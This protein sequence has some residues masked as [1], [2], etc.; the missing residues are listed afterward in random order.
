MR[1]LLISLIA[2]VAAGIVGVA[3]QS[4]S[5]I[6]LDNESLNY[7]V[8]YKWGLINKLAGHATM[9]LV[10]DGENYRAS[11]VASNAS[12][13]N[14]IYFLRD[15]L[16]S[17]MTKDKL[18]PIDYIFIAHEN[19]KYRKETVKFSRTGDTFFGECFRTIRKKKDG[20][21][22]TTETSLE[23]KGMTVDML[24]T[25]FYLR[26]LDFASMK[27][28]DSDVINIFSAKKKEKLS[29]TYR[30]KAKVK[31]DGKEH[32]TY[33]LSFTFTR[34]GVESSAPI[35]GWISADRR[36]IP[37]KVEGS[38]PVGKVRAIFSGETPVK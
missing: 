2:A 17:T 30:G 15:T 23:A 18:Y 8:Y 26:T 13:A 38:L 3:A 32:E 35:Y 10:T 5:V 6:S 33:M 4:N 14:K 16:Y 1:R 27:P 20:P 31:I 21:L 34:N 37:L 24:S 12:W 28:G 9:S 19:G 11:V 29:I 25:F 7:N 36:R 22:S